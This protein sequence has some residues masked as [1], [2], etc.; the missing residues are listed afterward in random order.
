M[1]FVTKKA[2]SRREALR[3][4][5]AMVALPFLDSMVPA[6]TPLAQ[7][8]A[9]PAIP[10]LGFVYAPNGMFLPNFHPAG[11][12]GSGYAMTPILRP[13]EAYR[14]Q[15]V[16]VTGLS[17][18]GIVS[19]N[20]GG[21]VHTRAHGGWL[22]GVLP[23]RTEGADIEA[24]KTV[25]QYAADVLGADTSLRSLE[26]T[27]ESN[28]TVGNCENGYSC[29][30]QNSTSWRSPTTPLPHERDPRVVFQRLF[31]DGGSVEARLAQMQT[32]RSILDSVMES[33]NQLERRLGRSD[34]AAVEE[35]LDAVREIERRIQ[36]A[37]QNSATTP[38]PTADQP[39]GVPDAYDE[40]V[41]MLFD[42]LALAYQADVTRV[43]CFQM[44]RELSGRTYPEIGVPEA[45]HSVSHHQL[46][47]HNIEQYTKINT[48]HVSL[49]SKLIE[50][51]HNTP[52]GDGTLLDHTIMLYGTGMGDGDHHTPYNLPVILV[53][54]GCGTL[55]G[56]RHMKYEMDTPF[57]N[58]G[59][60]LLDKVGVHL[61]G[62]ADSTGRLANL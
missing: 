56:G 37:E 47:P 42:M 46:N 18:K 38:L 23:K 11:E 10:R 15:M 25:D 58:L 27:T 3:G 35:Y 8:V 31:G 50:R 40:H 53:G 17:N 39:A 33:I 29:T 36:R 2:L 30:Y 28:F 20:E 59:L 22:S 41:V 24:G 4:M 57:M 43:S 13:L 12:G 9:A 34:R 7:T 45:H 19:P 49:F 52:D 62:I 16:V 1:N 55:E 48:H 51:M 44:A 61:D 32:D 54:G 21:G 60:T 14:D 6:L 26:L 5:G